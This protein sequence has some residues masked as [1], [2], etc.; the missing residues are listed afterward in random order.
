[1]RMYR[2][3]FEDNI[4]TFPEDIQ[5]IS[6]DGQTFVVACEKLPQE[7]YVLAEIINL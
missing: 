7:W 4:P 6:K 2:V 5:V 1:M 3:I